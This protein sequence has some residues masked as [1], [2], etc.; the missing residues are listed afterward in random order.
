MVFTPNFMQLEV[1]LLCPKAPRLIK[2][3]VCAVLL[4]TFIPR[5][6][7]GVHRDNFVVCVSSPLHLPSSLCISFLRTAPLGLEFQWE[8]ST[9]ICKTK[10]VC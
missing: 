3:I 5:C 9:A 1:Y 8:F 6:L 4:I 2:M 10:M 7:H